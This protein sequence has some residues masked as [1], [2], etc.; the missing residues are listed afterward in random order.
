MSLTNK[1]PANTYKDLFYLDN[2][3]SGIDNTL[4]DI[5]DGAGNTTAVSLSNKA[6]AVK[7]QTNNTAAL[8]VKN[9]SGTSKFIVDTS[10]NTVKALGTHVHTLYKHFAIYDLS[11][12]QNTHYTLINNGGNY[13]TSSITGPVAFGTS[14]DPLTILDISAQ[15]TN[16]SKFCLCYWYLQDAIK[17]DGI[18]VLSGS[19]AAQ[20]VEYHVLSYDLA[21][22]S[23][24]GD[25]SNGVLLAHTSSALSSGGN[26]APTIKQADLTIDQAVVTAGK[27]ILCFLKN[28]GGTG[29]VT[30]QMEIKYHLT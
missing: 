16:W 14:A 29:D 20:D 15:T 26:T 12:A 30:A 5:K 11:V 1:T 2:A 17:I 21:T 28:T 27:V 13:N 22:G 23:N 4:R 24:H 6:L 8:D 10:N 18:S 9:A 19:D 7:S 25:L 3:N